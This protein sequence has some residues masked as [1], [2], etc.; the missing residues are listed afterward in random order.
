M[1]ESLI[2]LETNARKPAVVIQLKDDPELFELLNKYRMTTG[3]TWKRCFLVGFAETIGRV[4]D[5]PELVV[6]IA[7]YLS[8]RR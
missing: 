6:R 7:D 2:E 3:W 5:N 8:G 1:N 4:G